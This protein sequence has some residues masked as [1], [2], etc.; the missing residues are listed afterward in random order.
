MEACLLYDIEVILSDILH[1]SATASERKIILLAADIQ[2]RLS[3]ASG[4]GRH[5]FR[6]T[7]IS[8]SFRLNFLS[9]PAA[10]V[11]VPASVPFA[12]LDVDVYIYHIAYVQGILVYAVAEEVETYL[13]R[14]VIGGFKHIFLFAP[15]IAGLRGARLQVKLL[16]YTACYDE[17]RHV[18]LVLVFFVII[19][20]KINEFSPFSQILLF[21]SYSFHHASLPRRELS[22]FILPNQ[23]YVVNLCSK[24]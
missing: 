7:Y 12:A 16:N 15:G 3:K 5:R 20:C 18:F 9:L 8:C 19:D 14:I 2:I 1:T 13:L 17:F 4:R 6:L 21:R 11:S 10:D 22:F 24:T 23:I